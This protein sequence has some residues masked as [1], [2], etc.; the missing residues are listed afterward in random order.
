MI[1]SN[2]FW[3]E[4]KKRGMAGWSGVN[5]ALCV[6]PALSVAHAE[7]LFHLTAL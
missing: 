4:V 7:G 5:E 1:H 6:T 2:I 3:R